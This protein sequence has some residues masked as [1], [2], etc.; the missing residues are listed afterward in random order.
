[1]SKTNTRYLLDRVQTTDLILYNTKLGIPL[2]L[3]VSL[4]LSL[5]GFSLESISKECELNLDKLYELLRGSNHVSDSVR[6][7]FQNIIRVDPWD[8]AR[9]NTHE[10][11]N[12]PEALLGNNRMEADVNNILDQIE[13]EYQQAC[14]NELKR[15]YGKPLHADFYDESSTIFLEMI[16]NRAMQSEEYRRQL[17]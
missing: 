10:K 3:T 6:N 2:D 17:K 11:L 12:V 9:V 7:I 5:Q 15:L 8:V 14:L 13:P 16:V 4:L 1:M